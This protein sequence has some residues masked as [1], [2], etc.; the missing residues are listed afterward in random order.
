M[1]TKS[2]LWL[3][4]KTLLDQGENMGSPEHQDRGHGPCVPAADGSITSCSGKLQPT[5]PQPQLILQSWRLLL[6]AM[7]YS[8]RVIPIGK[9]E[10]FAPR[11]RTG[12]R[13]SEL[14]AE[15]RALLS[16]WSAAGERKVMTVGCEAAGMSRTGELIHQPSPTGLTWSSPFYSILSSSLGFR[17]WKL[18]VLSPGFNPSPYIPQRRLGGNLAIVSF[19]TWHRPLQPSASQSISGVSHLLSC[20]SA[21]GEALSQQDFGFHLRSSPCWFHRELLSTDTLLPDPSLAWRVM[22]HVI[23]HAA[24]IFIQHHFHQP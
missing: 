16:G 4:L 5:L 15:P 3:P 2:I 21:V 20:P 7:P 22:A 6:R 17:P 10:G 8:G 1:W 23:P 18:S 24:T 14:Q 12:Y 11:C 9:R 13:L 19:Q